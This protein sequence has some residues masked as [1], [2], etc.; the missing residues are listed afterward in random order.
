VQSARV[1]PQCGIDPLR[2]DAH[3]KSFALS[4]FTAIERI[5]AGHE[6]G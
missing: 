3:L 6:S 4:A 5:S 1:L 2:A